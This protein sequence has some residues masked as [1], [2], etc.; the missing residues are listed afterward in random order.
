MASQISKFLKTK[1]KLWAYLLKEQVETVILVVSNRF[2]LAYTYRTQNFQ[3]LL[4]WHLYLHDLNNTVY[5]TPTDKSLYSVV[6]IIQQF[7][8]TL[9]D[10]L[11]IY[12]HGLV[13][14]E[15]QPLRYVQFDLRIPLDYSTQQTIAKLEYLLYLLLLI[16]PLPIQ[17]I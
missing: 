14:K 9:L 11:I 8:Q 17:T 7:S 1:H 13:E 15:L 6:V 16:L 5:G 12:H 3:V 4:V 2:T 10:I